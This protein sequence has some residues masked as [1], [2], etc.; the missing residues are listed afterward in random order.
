MNVSRWNVPAIVRS[1]ASVYIRS[2]D[3][4][5]LFKVTERRNGPGFER[6]IR[7]PVAAL[8]LP[9]R[10]SVDVTRTY[11]YS[12]KTRARAP[13]GRSTAK[14]EHDE[15]SAAAAVQLLLF[16]LKT[17]DSETINYRCHIKLLFP[18]ESTSLEQQLSR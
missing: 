1:S 4:L 17:T 8:P 15:M 3:P 18:K 12:A 2:A 13:A 6:T 11:A 5:L 7:S 16:S 9:L 10:R 14:E